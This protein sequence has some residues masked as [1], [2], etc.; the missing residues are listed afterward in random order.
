MENL[1]KLDKLADIAVQ[2]GW[3]ESAVKNYSALKK[4]HAKSW[5]IV[6]HAING[7]NSESPTVDF[8]LRVLSQILKLSPKQQLQLV[9]DLAN[10]TPNTSI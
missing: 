7:E 8:S 1:P 3:S 5:A 2:L 4:V 6:V 9:T 10:E